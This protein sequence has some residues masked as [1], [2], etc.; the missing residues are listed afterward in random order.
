MTLLGGGTFAEASRR[1]IVNTLE[2][3]RDMEHRVVQGTMLREE[4]RD[5]RLLSSEKWGRSFNSW[6]V[7]ID[8]TVM[9]SS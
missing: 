8:D 3:V 2:S 5:C 6:H 9:D 7:K 4:Q 1:Q